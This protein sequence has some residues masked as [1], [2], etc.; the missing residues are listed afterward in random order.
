MAI[1]V[2][3]DVAKTGRVPV[4][5]GTRNGVA[6]P[7]AQLKTLMA[8][9][10]NVYARR[11]KMLV[12]HD[13]LDTEAYNTTTA[14][15]TLRFRFHT[16][17]NCDKVVMWMRVPPVDA[18]IGAAP[19]PRVTWTTTISGGG[20]TTQDTIYYTGLRVTAAS[21]IIP[22]Q[23]RYFEQVWDL[24][25]NTTYEVVLNQ[26]DKLRVVGVQIAEITRNT[27]STISDTATNSVPIAQTQAIFDST[28]QDVLTD[29]DT[30]WKRGGQT[31][32]SYSV[33]STTARTTIST[34]FVNVVDTAF[35]AVGANNTGWFTDPGYRGLFDGATATQDVIPIVFSAYMQISD[36]A[37]TATI[38]LCD[39]NNAT[40][41]PIATLTRTGSTAAAW[42][43]VAANWTVP[44]GASMKLEA[45]IKTSNAGAT[46]SAYALSVF[47]YKT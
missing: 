41:A 7:G 20:A 42:V 18:T 31:F 15:D 9:A 30:I 4:E 10:N 8:F 43:S 36:A 19:S 14:A 23:Y 45:F 1:I 2:I 33:P 47:Q 37:Q 46:A 21:A 34:T 3:G 5:W 24:D 28:S 26:V 35:T 32:V 6:P 25:A 39:D 29:L 44:F 38:V 13:A 40:G 12:D 16:S 22:D 27:M 17:P 11:L